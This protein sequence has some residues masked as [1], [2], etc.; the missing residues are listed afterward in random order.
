MSIVRTNASQNALL[1]GCLMLAVIAGTPAL[2]AVNCNTA[3][4]ICD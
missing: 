1:T 2:A 3:A 4:A